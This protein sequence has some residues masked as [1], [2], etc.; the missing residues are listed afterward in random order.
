MRRSPLTRLANRRNFSSIFKSFRFMPWIEI[1]ISLIGNVYAFFVF[2]LSA[3]TTPIFNFVLRTFVCLFLAFYPFSRWNTHP[4]FFRLILAH[5]CAFSIFA[6]V[7]AIFWWWFSPKWLLDVCLSDTSCVYVCACERKTANRLRRVLVLIQE[8]QF[9]IS[10]KNAVW[11]LDVCLSWYKW[12]HKKR[13]FFRP[14]A[15]RV[16]IYTSGADF[17]LRMTDDRRVCLSWYK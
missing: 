2:P 14:W 10:V 13:D 6:T 17:H 7:F 4:R 9:F 5:F 16:P 15:Q 11:H 12:A 3:R 8:E 1:V